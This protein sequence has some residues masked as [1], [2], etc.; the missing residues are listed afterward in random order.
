MATRAGYATWF[1][2]FEEKGTIIRSMSKPSSR[3]S[4]AVPYDTITTG[5]V[6]EYLI[7]VGGGGLNKYTNCITYRTVLFAVLLFR[8]VTNAINVLNLLNFITL[9]LLVL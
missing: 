3:I 2:P 5:P 8:N 9:L 1:T 7:L 6:E 4:G